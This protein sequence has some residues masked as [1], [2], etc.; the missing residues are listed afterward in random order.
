MECACQLFLVHSSTADWITIVVSNPF[1]PGTVCFF[2]SLPVANYTQTYS[3]TLTNGHTH[4]NILL[5]RNPNDTY[6]YK[7]KL[8]AFLQTRQTYTTKLLLYMI[9]F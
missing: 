6:K 9:Y 8:S 1:N 4:T 3:E 7:P 2:T 5:D